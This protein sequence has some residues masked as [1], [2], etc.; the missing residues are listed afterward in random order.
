MDRSS[1]TSRCR[2]LGVMPAATLGLGLATAIG[3]DIDTDY[4]Y[5]T[6]QGRAVRDSNQPPG[7]DDGFMSTLIASGLGS[8]TATCGPDNGLFDP[9]LYVLLHEENEVVAMDTLGLF[10]PF[11][12]LAGVDEAA[13]DPS[14]RLAFDRTGHYGSTLFV[15]DLVDETADTVDPDGSVGLFGLPAPCSALAFD[16]YGAFDG[17]LFAVDANGDLQAMAADGTVE[18]FAP[19][20][21]SR[22]TMTFAP[23]GAFG[24]AL[25]LADPDGGRIHRI[26]P[27]HPAGEPAPIW[28]IESLGIDVL[29]AAP[30]V[31]ALSSSGSFGNEVM[32]VFDERMQAVHRFGPDGE[33]QGVFATGLSSRVSIE[34]PHEGLFAGSMIMIIDDEIWVVRPQGSSMDLI[35]VLG[36][37]GV[38]P[39]DAGCEADLDDDGD[40]DYV[41][42]LLFLGDLG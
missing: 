13:G 41:D 1:T 12:D 23:E 24:P 21:G 11:A 17:R 9:G 10:T 3:A 40:V 35:D 7:L 22:A 18:L 8:I 25:Y 26:E 15:G 30:A 31:L 29:A 27:T 20:V 4:P 39:D 6:E 42:L 19:N 36:A 32:Y 2:F 33:S 5:H 37:W 14:A 28:V 34:L 16:P 38:C